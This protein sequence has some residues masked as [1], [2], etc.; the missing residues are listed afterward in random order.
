MRDE[1]DAVPKRGIASAQGARIEIAPD[2][3]AGA[4]C[5]NRKESCRTPLPKGPQASEP[6]LDARYIT[7]LRNTAVSAKPR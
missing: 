3:E 1:G 4:I 5:S 2:R 7:R 6:P